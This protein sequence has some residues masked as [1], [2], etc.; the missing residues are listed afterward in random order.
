MIFT[1]HFLSINLN[2]QKDHINDHNHEHDHTF[3]IGLANTLVY[4]AKEKES[5]YGIHLHVI[6]SIN[7][8]KFGIGLGYERIF[9]EH[10]HNTL[11]IITSYN[12]TEKIHV[13]LTP[14]IAFAGNNASEKH[15]ALH[16]ETSYDYQ[17]ANLHLGPMIE[18][19]ID[20]EDFHVSLG[21]HIGLGL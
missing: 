19:A 8:S 5:A 17:I 1:I 3:E 15:L 11:G 14:G 18:F 20:S 12:P 16:L 13:S 7:H 10:K 21:I 2:A 9:D 4:F 6:K